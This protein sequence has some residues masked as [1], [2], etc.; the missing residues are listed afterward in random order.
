M[1]PYSV[2]FL[3]VALI[4]AALGDGGIVIKPTELA[5]IL[6]SVLAFFTVSLLSSRQTPG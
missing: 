4:A 5:K 2:I 3:F 1:L 6:F